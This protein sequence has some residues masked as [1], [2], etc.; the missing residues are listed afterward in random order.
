[1]H[2]DS[3]FSAAPLGF[4]DAGEGDELAGNDRLSLL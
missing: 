4:E 1:V 2:V 3:N